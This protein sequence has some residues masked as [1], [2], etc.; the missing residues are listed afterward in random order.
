[1]LEIVLTRPPPKSW[2]LG[3]SILP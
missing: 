2:A 1:M 3:L